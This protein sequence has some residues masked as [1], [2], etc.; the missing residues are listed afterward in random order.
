MPTGCPRL[1]EETDQEI[2]TV[3]VWN[4]SAYSSAT[5]LKRQPTYYHPCQLGDIHEKSED[6]STY[7][8]QNCAHNWGLSVMINS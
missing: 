8:S 6:S 4:I 5:I 3:I 1:P 2:E 7:P